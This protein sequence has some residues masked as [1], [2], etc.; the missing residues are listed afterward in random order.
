MTSVVPAASPHACSSGD[1]VWFR[2]WPSRRHEDVEV[3]EHSDIM[4][5]IT[6]VSV[7]T[8]E[9]RVT[10]NGSEAYLRFRAA[11]SPA[12]PYPTLRLPTLRGLP[13]AGSGSCDGGTL[14]DPEA[15]CSSPIARCSGSRMIISYRVNQQP[16]SDADDNLASRPA[17]TKEDGTQAEC[18]GMRIA[19]RGAEPWTPL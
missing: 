6:T 19:A 12:L 4:F 17:R 9:I 2:D 11:V 15:S 13:R 7:P 16:C 18:S 5:I 14:Q 8:T 1:D 3:A 10:M